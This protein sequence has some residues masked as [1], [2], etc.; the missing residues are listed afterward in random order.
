MLESNG[1]A[2]S[3]RL[4]LFLSKIFALHTE[5][6]NPSNLSLDPPLISQGMDF[7]IPNLEVMS[8]ILFLLEEKWAYYYWG[9]RL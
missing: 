6:Y 1:D 9:L 7:N 8:N 4:T 2:N 3:T 5:K